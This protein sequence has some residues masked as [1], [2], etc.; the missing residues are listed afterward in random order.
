MYKYYSVSGNVCCKQ[1]NIIDYI[2]WYKWFL[3]HFKNLN[4]NFS[5]TYMYKYNG[6]YCACEII[7]NCVENWKIFHC[8][9]KQRVYVAIPAVVI[10]QSIKVWVQAVRILPIC[11]NKVGIPVQTL[12]PVVCHAYS[13]SVCLP[14][15]QVTVTGSY[16]G[17]IG[18]EQNAGGAFQH[19]KWLVL[20]LEQC[21]V[22]VGW[23]VSQNFPVYPSGQAQW[24]RRSPL[25]QE[26]PF[27]QGLGSQGDAGTDADIKGLCVFFCADTWG[28]L[29]THMSCSWVLERGVCTC[30]HSR[31]IFSGWPHSRHSHTWR[32]RKGSLLENTS[33]PSKEIHLTS[34]NG[35][36][37][38]LWISWP[39]WHLLPT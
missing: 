24:K 15:S 16:G 6:N 1:W 2:D 36:Q 8:F 27:L 30:T 19:L 20:I 9:I 37:D 26:A 25:M 23:P 7:Q 35:G 32:S 21:W 5:K 13:T 12:L 14:V 39:F 38:F 11:Q 33:D 3:D 18:K 31:D 34:I 22:S 28:L 17:R 4:S 29:L 10:L